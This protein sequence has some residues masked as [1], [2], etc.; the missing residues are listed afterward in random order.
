MITFSRL[1]KYGR[2]GNQMFQYA[3]IIGIAKK[4]GYNYCF[5]LSQ[6]RLQEIFNVTAENRYYP[7]PFTRLL[8]Y[9]DHKFDSKF[10]ELPDEIDYGGFFQTE[11]FFKHCEEFIRKEFTFKQH[12]VDS[13]FTTIKKQKYIAIHVRRTDYLELQDCHPC[14]TLEWYSRAMEYFPE[15][16]FMIFTDDKEWCMD[17][18]NKT[19]CTISPFMTAEED[20]YAMT[21]C[22]GHIIAN[23]TFSWWG[24]W[25]ANSKKVVAP[26]QWYGPRAGQSEWE[27]VYCEGW[28]VL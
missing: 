23:S 20:L 10:F 19:K 2:L 7:L 25:L 5:P 26:K 27:D 8:N 3:A 6:T 13:V 15:E 21:Q 17:N 24:A 22:E 18:F 12:I 14:P 4:S 1:G 11:K 16:K 9:N 28:I